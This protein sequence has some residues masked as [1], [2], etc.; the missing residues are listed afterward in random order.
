MLSPLTFDFRYHF[1]K[2]DNFVNDWKKI[3]GLRLVAQNIVRLID[4]QFGVDFG[5]LDFILQAKKS[6][7]NFQ[8]FHMS[9]R[10]PGLQIVNPK[11]PVPERDGVSGS[12]T[13]FRIIQRLLR[14][15]L[16]PDRVVHVHVQSFLRLWQFLTKPYAPRR[17]IMQ[18]DALLG[19]QISGVRLDDF[20]LVIVDPMV[21]TGSEKRVF[22]VKI[23]MP[24]E[25]HA[26]P[27]PCFLEI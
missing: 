6:G 13:I 4:P 12:E 26:T 19:R 1:V 23:Q 14:R 3:L 18:H 11:Q 16:K 17:E 5:R 2:S 27:P 7:V 10:D 25:V 22:P 24:V 8:L 21:F 15:H 9:R 20:R